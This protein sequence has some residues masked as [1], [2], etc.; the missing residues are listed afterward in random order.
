MPET[1]ARILVLG[2]G[3]I[4]LETALYARFLGFPV[5]VIERG[6]SAAANVASW[7][8]VQLFTPFH[9]NATSLGVAAIQAQDAHWE[10]PAG[11]ALL[12]GAEYQSKYLQKLAATDLLA[13]NMQTN[14]TVLSIGR[15]GWL[16]HEGVGDP[17]RAE[18]PFHVLC[19]DTDGVEKIH[20]ADLVIDCTGT[21]GNHNWLGQG[22]IPARGEMSAANQIEYGIPAILGHDSD[23]YQGKHTLVVGAGYSAATVITQLARLSDEQSDT[24]V[25]WVTRCPLETAPIGRI[26]DDRLSSRDW[27]A[28]AANRLAANP[29]GLLS[30]LAETS[31]AAIEYRTASNDFEVELTGPS[32]GIQTFDR[33]VA[34]VG[35]RP[36]NQIY[37][38]LQFHECYAS[39][40]PMKLAAQASIKSPAVPKASSIPN[41][42]SM[43]WAV[44]ATDADRSFY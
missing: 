13:G 20:E 18:A 10:P 23:R 3:P 21:Y 29:D 4:G 41:Q 26:T 2:A 27:L 36:D 30:Y 9:I 33:I 31:V 34:N 16:K 12:T 40:G 43:S 5:E 17:Q 38:E 8:H 19:R 1:S 37:A 28:K 24:R 22:G 15:A 14:T 25:T 6:E 11:D 42:T 35:Y 44:K 7:G 32:A 39:G